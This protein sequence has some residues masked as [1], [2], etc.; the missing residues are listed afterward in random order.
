MS[1]SILGNCGVYIVEYA[2]FWSGFKRKNYKLMMWHVRFTHHNVA[3][4]KVM[5]QKEMVEGIKSLHLLNFR[6][7]FRC[8]TCQRATQKRMSYQ[9]QEGKQQKDYYSR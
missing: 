2:K 4:M 3:A 9:R 5:V 7:Q 8:I 6:G 1:W